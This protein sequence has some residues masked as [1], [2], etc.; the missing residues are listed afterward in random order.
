MNVPIPGQRIIDLDEIERLLKP[1]THYEVS[2]KLIRPDGRIEV[3]MALRVGGS[4]HSESRTNAVAVGNAAIEVIEAAGYEHV[5]APRIDID[6]TEVTE[7][8]SEACD[9]LVHAQL[10]LELIGKREAR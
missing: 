7:M 6:S 10:W 5:S 1:H 2:I 4:T 8:G 3:T 9:Y